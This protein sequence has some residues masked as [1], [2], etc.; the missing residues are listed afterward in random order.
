MQQSD[1]TNARDAGVASELVDD[2]DTHDTDDT[3]PLSLLERRR[4][5][6][7]TLEASSPGA[8]VPRADSLGIVAFQHASYGAQL[9]THPAL[10]EIV[11]QPLVVPTFDTTELDAQAD[12]FRAA[13]RASRA[14]D[15][16]NAAELLELGTRQVA[17]GEEQA[18]ILRAQVERSRVDGS[19]GRGCSG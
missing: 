7:A 6:A 15:L 11:Q 12:E 14:E 16:A 3:K 4:L 10:P 5:V 19:T 9:P 8:D 1:P 17:L 18:A 13:N 2:D